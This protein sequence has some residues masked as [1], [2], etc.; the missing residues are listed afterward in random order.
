MSKN[1][2]FTNSDSHFV[3]SCGN[4]ILSYQS[5]SKKIEGI[6]T[7]TQLFRFLQFKQ[8]AVSSSE[9][10]SVSDFPKQDSSDNSE[11]D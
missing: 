8:S 1:K 7:L 11:C 10:E 2:K 9:S 3:F 5:K 4:W 6:P